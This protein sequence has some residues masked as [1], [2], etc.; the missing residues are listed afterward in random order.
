MNYKPY[1]IYESF[2]IEQANAK[3]RPYRLPKNFEEHLVNK[4]SKANRDSLLKA[5][6]YFNT[7]WRNINPDKFME[8]GFELWKTFSYTMF[9]NEKL[10]KYYIQKDR[11]R[12]LQV[13]TSKADI[14]NSVKFVK[15]YMSDNGIPTLRAY[16]LKEENGTR[17]FVKHY[18]KENN[19]DKLLVVWFIKERFV[20]LNEDESAIMPHITGHY[21][22]LCELLNEINGFLN[23]LKEVV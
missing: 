15:K 1:D 9:F 12:K 16:C 7:K 22:D 17:L 11:N 10:I 18:I 23:K 2:R 19:I 8:Y 3:N 20:V 14:V 13:K 5:T 4:M 21:R 6:D